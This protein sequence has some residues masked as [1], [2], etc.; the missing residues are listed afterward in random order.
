VRHQGHIETW[1]DDR[2]FGFITPERGNGRLFDHIKSFRR[3]GRRPVIGAAV[4][5]IVRRDGEGRLQA[6][7]VAFMDASMAARTSLDQLAAVVAAAIALLG[8]GI[9]TALGRLP[10]WVM[11]LYI[12]ASLLTFLAYALDKSAAHHGRWRI[13]E[14]TLHALSLAGGWPGALM[15]QR[16]LRHKSKKAAFQ[17]TFWVTVAVN[18]AAL[19]WL[20]VSLSR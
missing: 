15:G 20:Y 4:S 1:L 5:Y 8:V 14:R 18:I 7:Q 17:T 19:A 16:W 10:V 12:A 6:S 2:G 9:A 13:P 11:L 3:G